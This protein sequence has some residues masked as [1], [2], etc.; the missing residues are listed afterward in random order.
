MQAHRLVAVGVALVGVAGCSDVLGPVILPSPPPDVRPYVSG[1]AL[2]SLDEDGH[3]RLPEATVDGPYAIIAQEQ[4]AAIALGV[5]RTWYANPDATTLPG[6]GSLIESAEEEHGGNID[7]ERVQLGGRPAYF[8]ESHLEPLPDSSGN[9]AIRAYGPHYLVPLFVD[10]T[11]VVVVGVAA[12]ATNIY[13]TQ[14]GFVR[15]IDNLDGGNEFRVSGIPLALGGTTL[16]PSPET[17]VE[18]AWTETGTRVDEVPVLGVP[19]NRVSRT[20][21]RWRLELA[22]DVDFE[23]L[24]DGQVVASSEVYVGVWCSIYDARLGLNEPCEEHLRLFVAAAAQPL[25]EEIEGVSLPLRDGYA[26]D[27]NEVRVRR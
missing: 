3:F 20:G 17:A 19:G 26:V 23:R 8:A 5:V 21:A 13:I 12:Y 4:A 7:W 1:S 22:H 16:P 24:I 11:P 6:M 2:A 15:R 9:P 18:F 10:A 25:T 27:L 14:D